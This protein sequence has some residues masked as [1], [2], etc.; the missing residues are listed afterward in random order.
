MK[1]SKICKFLCVGLSLLAFIACDTPSNSNSSVT[2]VSNPSSTDEIPSADT[3]GNTDTDDE[4]AKNEG[5]EGENSSPS[6]NASSS[7]SL[8]PFTTETVNYDASSLK[9][10][11]DGEN[12]TVTLAFDGTPKL[13]ENDRIVIMID[14]ENLSTGKTSYDSKG[15]TNAA[16]YMTVDSS[17]EFY[18]V[19][20][21]K[22]GLSGSTMAKSHTWVQADD[23]TYAPSDSSTS[24]VYTIALTNIDSSATSSDTFKVVVFVSSYAWAEDAN[25]TYVQDALPST[26]VSVS[27]TT[28]QNDTVSISFA[29]ALSVDGVY[30]KDT[31]DDFDDFVLGF[32][33]SAVYY[34]EQNGAVTWSDTDG[35]TTEFFALLKKHGV[36]T[37]RL[38]IW[39]D[40]SN[41]PSGAD[42]TGNCDIDHVIAMAKRIKDAGLKLM[43]DFHYSDTWADPGKQI[44]PKAWASLSSAE[45]VASAISEYTTEVLETIKELADVTPYYVQIGNEINPGLLLHTGYNSST[46]YGSG[47]FAYAAGNTSENIVTYLTAASKAVRSFNEK[48][49]IVVHV[50]S[51]N[52]PETILNTLKKGNLD[53]DVIGLSYYP[54]YSSHGTIATMKSRVSGWKTTYGK[55]V[56]IAETA[57]DGDCDTSD[58]VV[59]RLKAATENLIDPD[60]SAVYSDLTLDSTDTYIIGS[61]SNQH[62]VLKHIMD[63]ADDS[64][65]LGIC[66]WGGE[67]RD[68]EHGMFSWGG[69]AFESIDVFKEYEKQ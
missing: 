24:L 18:A 38:R 27:Q 61:E 10:V 49:K 30:S 9:V 66:T 6:G 1:I 37:V 41:A 22:Y 17:L 56:L 11:N 47:T 4:R 14:D 26:A 31:L 45:E 59:A 40:P 44:V 52:S 65:S 42:T 29:D 43:L 69:K 28:S 25:C 3:S 21:P 62:K 55:P 48:I 5:E 16:S 36:N 53:Y 50:A 7:E 12:L 54:R 19:D 20:L 15:W 63:E 60:T 68:W 58:T 46:G 8:T 39:N 32:D 23:Y 67:I 13:W 57:F 51:S 34:Y 33:A 35:T 2:V 64:G